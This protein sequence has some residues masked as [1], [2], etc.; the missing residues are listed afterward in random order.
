ME[1]VILPPDGSTRIEHQVDKHNETNTDALTDRMPNN[2]F[3]RKKRIGVR[4]L[5][6]RLD[7]EVEVSRDV[8]KVDFDQLDGSDYR[9]NGMENTEILV[10]VLLDSAIRGD[11]NC[12]FWSTGFA[13]NFET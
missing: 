3:Q 7:V 5:L 8:L 9:V 11:K 2:C 13:S 12:N 6:S 1:S 4:D 10:L